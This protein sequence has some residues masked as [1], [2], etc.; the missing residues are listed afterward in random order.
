[1]KPITRLPIIVMALFVIA[2]CQ[3]E[4]VYAQDK[5][6]NQSPPGQ[7]SKQARKK[8]W[9][10]QHAIDRATKKALKAHLKHQ[11]KAV[12]KRMKKDAR[13]ARKNNSR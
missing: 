9:K 3:A 1:M 11:T 8:Q 2:L 6:S 7:M 5:Q 12:R 10:K 13:E 4:N